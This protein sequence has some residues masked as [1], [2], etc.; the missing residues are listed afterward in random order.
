MSLKVKN[1]E[2]VKVNKSL[3]LRLILVIPFVL[4]VFA[5]VGLVGYFA[6]V[7]SQ[8]AINNLANQLIDSTSKQVD[9]HLDSY[10][11]L[12][13][14]IAQMNLD[15]IG[16]KELDL[17]NPITSGRYF[18]K[19]GKAFKN[20]SYIGYS[21]IDGR[22]AGIARWT[23]GTD[24]ILYENLKGKGK[25]LEYFPDD[26]GNRTQL[27]VTYDYDP[28]IETSYQNAVKTR[29]LIWG[30]VEVAETSPLEF[31]DVGKALLAAGEINNTG[32]G[33]DYYAAISVAAPIY[34]TNQNLLGVTSVDIMLNKINDFLQELKVSPSGQVFIIQRDGQ[35]I[36]SSSK[37]STLNTVNEKSQLYQVNDSP[38]PLIRNVYNEV[39]KQFNNLNKIQQEHQINI[40]L[41]G[42]KTFVRIKPWRDQYG[43]D[44][45]IVVTVPESDFM[46]QIYANTRTTILLCLLALMIAIAL[47]I[48]TSRWIIQPIL[49]LSDA[50]QAITSGELDK[51][52]EPSNIQEINIL[53]Y[54]FNRMAEQLNES[55]IALKTINLQL[56][57]RVEER[58]SELKETL[59]ELQQAQAQIIQS[60]K[61][62]SLG[63][64]VAGVAHEINN[65]VNFIHG[66]ITYLDEYTQDLL[67]LVQLYQSEYPQPSLTIQEELKN[68]DL[69]FIQEDSTKILASMKM[70]TE[71]I[72]EIVLSLRNFSRLDEAE[73][74]KVDIHEG[75]ESTLLIL[76]HRF[77]AK[78]NFPMIQIIKNYGSLPLVECYAGQ[79]NQV[80]LNILTNAI[81]ALQDKVGNLIPTITIRT[82]F[83]NAQ[84]IEIAIADNGVGMSEDIQKKIFDPFFT[85]KPVG[86]GTG[87]GM[88]IS[89]QIITQ[90]HGGKLECVSTLGVGTEFLIQI[91][92]KP[93]S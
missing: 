23:K 18:W 46:E 79:L 62:S 9:G 6:T 2:S 33:Y 1:S 42:N 56:E 59:Q 51:Q 64:M 29:K 89:Y 65:P 68:L 93:L 4:E 3:K 13:I 16:N 27:I 70:G 66:N 39:K 75:I 86:K 81:D 37:Y 21:L 83:V 24:L 34:D 87:M 38:D 45:L 55:F 7:N 28:S 63:Q 47:G 71:R 50:A 58:T 36:G 43:L 92:P 30:N 74:K 25:A 5:A 91:P 85:T 77:N 40:L 10:L 57:N 61:M 41:N 11:S 19:Q 35:I 72:E 90:K 76:Q 60:E 26:K 31:S 53:N 15:A 67:N 52:L 73:M 8:Q 20:I 82:S 88:S 44:W 84:W 69:E 78:L 49:K 54:A 17:D 80:F 32:N 12:P 14:Q 48:Y 22:E